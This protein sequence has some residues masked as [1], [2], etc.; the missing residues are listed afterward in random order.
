MSLR[1]TRLRMRGD[2]RT[3]AM[4]SI[5]KQETAVYWRPIIV[6][7]CPQGKPRNR[8]AGR[9]DF[10][11]RLSENGS[12]TLPGLPRTRVTWTRNRELRPGRTGPE[13]TRRPG[14]PKGDE[15]PAIG[16]CPP[17][18]IWPAWPSATEPGTSSLRSTTRA[19]TPCSPTAMHW[20]GSGSLT[21]QLGPVSER[22]PRRALRCSTRG[23]RRSTPVTSGRARWRG[24]CSASATWAARPMYHSLTV[25]WMCWLRYSTS[26]A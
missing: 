17:S 2:Y 10:G 8:Y 12:R 23:W 7:P 4:G 3:P 19:T 14:T 5:W 1:H 21:R 24:G 6:S 26:G 22:S 9:M 18:P 15:S 13:G 25:E 11:C 20:S 16:R